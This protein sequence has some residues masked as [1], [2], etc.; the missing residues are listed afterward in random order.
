[1]VLGAWTGRG[2]AWFFYIFLIKKKVH[3]HHLLA[4]GALKCHEEFDLST[5]KQRLILSK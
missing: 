5:I 1:M 3:N 2:L 4:N